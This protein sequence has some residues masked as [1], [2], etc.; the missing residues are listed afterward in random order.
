M[1]NS[2]VILVEGHMCQFGMHSHI[3]KVDGDHGWVKKPTGFLTSSRFV[4]D[5]LS[6]RCKTDHD[7]VQLVGGRAAGAQVYPDGLCRAML[8]GVA[9][10]KKYDGDSKVATTPM[11]IGDTRRFIGSLSS[12]CLGTAKEVLEEGLRGNWPK[13]WVDEVHEPDGGN[14]E[15]GLRPQR[16]VEILESELQSLTFRDG[17]AIAKDDV[18]G[19]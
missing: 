15:F 5:Q 18:S 9:Q 16:G 3:D 4:A 12:V 8:R 6:R 13:H 19:K 11:S 1:L 17:I 2:R 14:D 10:Q 7:H